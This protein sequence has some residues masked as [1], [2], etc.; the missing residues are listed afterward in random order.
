MRYWVSS[1][2]T[3]LDKEKSRSIYIYFCRWQ[4]S[5][6]RIISSSS[7][8]NTGGSCLGSPTRMAF[9]DT[10]KGMR[11]SG[12]VALQTSSMITTSNISAEASYE[13]APTR[14]QVIPTIFEDKVN[15]F[16]KL[17]SS[18]LEI[19]SIMS[20]ASSSFSKFF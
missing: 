3:H 2:V 15:A 20:S 16:S 11:I 12:K 14:L 1:N 17:L 13:Y 18:Y 19:V 10:V 4:F 7:E 6:L 5:M 9:F 8:Q